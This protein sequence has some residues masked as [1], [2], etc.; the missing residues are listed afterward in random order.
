MSVSCKAG[1]RHL[2]QA[3]KHKIKFVRTPNESKASYG[4]CCKKDM[5]TKTCQNCKVEFVIEQ[6]DFN[7]YEKMKV[8][9]PIFWSDIRI[10]K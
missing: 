1:A 10:Y 4:A 8:S 3:W 2:K 9:P 5:E 7:F 6:E